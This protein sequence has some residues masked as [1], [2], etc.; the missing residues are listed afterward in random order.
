MIEERYRLLGALKGTEGK[1]PFWFMRQAGRYLPEYRALRKEASSFLDFCY[2]PEM[3]TE[4]TLQ[5]IRRFGMSAAIIFSD[6]LVIPHAMGIEVR[7]VEGQGPVLE[8]VR[9]AAEMAV[10][11]PRPERLSPV[12]EALR[13]TRAALPEGT[14]LIGFAGA[15]WTLACYIVQGKGD[16]DYQQVRHTAVTEPAFFDALIERLTKEVIAHLSA[17]IEAGAQAVQIFDSWAG[18]LPAEMFRT[19]AIQPAA[20]IVAALKEKHPGVPVIGFPR[21]AGVNYPEYVHTVRPDGISFDSGVPAPWAAQHLASLATPQGNLDP[22]LLAGD[23]K[24][25]LDQAK[26]ILD[27]FGHKPF[28]FNLGHGILPHTPVDTVAALCEMLRERVAG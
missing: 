5:P 8:P 9:S 12:Y 3:A 6:I 14:A 17:Q 1:V 28:V 24:G 10:L 23:A 11:E 15:P 19:Y 27:A 20:R 26:I 7:F 21:L 22:V 25:A 4:A 2:A 16:R 13:R 18:V